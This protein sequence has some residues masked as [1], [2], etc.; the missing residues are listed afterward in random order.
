MEG[1][2]NVSYGHPW[3]ISKTISK[4]ILNGIRWLSSFSCYLLFSHCFLILVYVRQLF[5]V[6]QCHPIHNK[7]I[8]FLKKYICKYIVAFLLANSSKEIG[9]WISEDFSLTQRKDIDFFV[10]FFW[11]FCFHV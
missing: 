11:F 8:F 3:I 1:F 7:V 10:L 5:F 4:T 9:L 2:L 6:K